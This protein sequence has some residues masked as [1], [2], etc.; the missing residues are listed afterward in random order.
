MVIKLNI[1]TLILLLLVYNGIVYGFEIGSIGS[2]IRSL[3]GFNRTNDSS[4]EQLKFNYKSYMQHLDL[5]QELESKCS[6]I[7]KIYKYDSKKGLYCGESKCQYFHIKLGLSNIN[8]DLPNVLFVSGIH[9]DEKLGVEIATELVS[10]ICDQYINHGNVG[11]NYLLSTRNIWIIPIANPWGF[12]HNKRTEEEIDVNRDFPSKSGE[13]CLK[14]ESSRMIYDLFNLNSFVFV[15]ALHGGL[16]SISYGNG[17]FDEND[18][19]NKIFE[20]IAKDLQVSA[21]KMLNNNDDVNKLTYYYD[22]I[23]N[24][25]ETVYPVKGGF[26][27]WSLY[28]YNVNHIL[29]SDYL[30]KSHPANKGGS[31]T[32]LVETDHQKTPNQ[33]SLGSKSDLFSLIDLDKLSIQPSHITRNIRMLL[34][35]AEYAYPDIIFFNKP[36]GTVYFGQTFVLYL[37]V[38]GCYSFSNLRLKLESNNHINSTSNPSFEQQSIY[39]NFYV[40][41]GLDGPQSTIYYK[42]CSSIFLNN[43]EI[44]DILNNDSFYA[45]KNKCN[46]SNLLTKIVNRSFRVKNKCKSIFQFNKFKPIKILVKVPN[47]TK[48]IS[49]INGEIQNFKFKVELEF[50]TELT[51]TISYSNKN[52]FEK[53]TKLRSS[54]NGNKTDRPII[55][56]ISQKNISFEQTQ[57][58]ELQSDSNSD[59]Q[60]QSLLLS[61]FQMKITKPQEVLQ[62]EFSSCSESSKQNIAKW[63][64]SCLNFHEFTKKALN[65]QKP[66]YKDSKS[67]SNIFHYLESNVIGN[68]INYRVFQDNIKYI[69]EN[70][71]NELE[72]NL[73]IIPSEP[74][75]SII[76]KIATNGIQNI[77]IVKPIPSLLENESK[78]STTLPYFNN[79]TLELAVT[80][81]NEPKSNGEYVI[82]KFAEFLNLL[83]HNISRYHN[84]EKILI[85]SNRKLN[86]VGIISISDFHGDDN[87]EFPFQ[88]IKAISRQRI[89]EMVTEVQNKEDFHKFN[90]ESNIELLEKYYIILRYL[91]NNLISVALGKVHIDRYIKN[92]LGMNIEELQTLKNTNINLMEDFN[93]N[94]KGYNNIQEENK[95]NNEEPITGLK[96]QLKSWWYNN[97]KDYMDFRLVLVFCGLLMIIFVIILISIKIMRHYNWVPLKSLKLEFK[98]RFRTNSKI[99]IIDILDDE[100][101]DRSQ[102]KE[103]RKKRRVKSRKIYDSQD[104]SYTP[105]SDYL[106][107]KNY[108]LSQRFN[109]NNSETSEKARDTPSNSPSSKEFKLSNLN[110]SLSHSSLSSF[111]NF[112]SRS[113]TVKELEIIEMERNLDIG[114]ANPNPNNNIS[115]NTYTE[116]STSI[117]KNMS[118]NQEDT[119]DY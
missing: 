8:Y 2:Y 65:I 39:L 81:S 13:N 63:N 26:E 30:Q 58:L 115:K 71:N 70:S 93:N 117:S 107:N 113:N 77:E 12:Y 85:N 99:F 102:D 91:K 38:I 48:I 24:I 22:Q 119:H 104:M 94:F 51:Q 17:Y 112:K 42:R 100:D 11:I 36:P 79:I 44:K 103:K 52:L 78:I 80:V 89:Y 109:T 64:K 6:N 53:F 92:S 62:I 34:K 18:D 105:R 32:F 118:Q 49:S 21:G 19:N 83:S 28:G 60:S 73:Y 46:D 4:N 108:T 84:I 86:F 59:G 55:F 35:L 95:S 37:A 16:R 41:E 9:G 25:A 116:L 66:S 27:D 1:P 87:E 110:L 50:D 75:T 96:E 76:S 61:G 5:L 29:C 3:V 57:K 40:N 45:S 15:A 43:Q 14:S 20:F 101:S 97:S 98:K 68:S 47:E 114:I 10:S 74:R 67:F 82:L 7:M 69:Q 72:G 31:L 23:G 90:G 88:N 106:S 56:P 33:D 54:Q 111:D